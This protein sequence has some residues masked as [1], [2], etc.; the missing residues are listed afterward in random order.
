M[1]DFE[2]AFCIQRFGEGTEGAEG[3]V[4]EAAASEGTCGDGADIGEKD[5]MAMEDAPQEGGCMDGAAAGEAE[6]GGDGMSGDAGDAEADDGENNENE[7]PEDA[8][9]R[10]MQEIRLRRDYA[11]LLIQAAAMKARYPGFDL[12]REMDNPAFARMVLPCPAGAGVAMEDAFY[13]VHRRE[14]QRAQKLRHMEITR[15]AVNQA[16][17]KAAR[18]IASGAARP[19]ENGVVPVAGADSR[20]DPGAL[21]GEE[22]ARIRKMVADGK[23]VVL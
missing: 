20:I 7:S 4:D 15:Y 13:A 5:A 8:A 10:L 3:V 21:S 17:R 18:A 2:G 11:G 9:L 16:R 12:D 23:K 6:A 22:R 1:W 14:L 19:V